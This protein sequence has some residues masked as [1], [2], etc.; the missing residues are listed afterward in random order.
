MEHD[1]PLEPD[2]LVEVVEEGVDG[3]R[4]ADV[5]P[6]RPGV[7]RVEA[8]PEPLG[9]DAPGQRRHRGCPA[10]SVTSV[11]SPNPL[12]GEFSRTTIA[13]SGPS[14][15]SASVSASPSARRRVPAAT[16]APRCDP[17]WTL[18][19]RPRN[20]GAARRSLART[21]TERPKKSSSGP[22]RLTRYE[23]WM[24][25]GR[26]VELGQAR[27]EGRLLASAARPGGARRSGCR[28]RSGARRR[29][30]RAPG[31]RP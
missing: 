29:R 16:P 10:S 19:N 31:R 22:A 14:S 15:T 9:G 23:A 4:L 12:P 5:D 21:S 3:G 20:P 2:P 25:I 26:D 6:G 8:E 30:S 17:T 24:A 27:P 11:P 18:T 28:R 1:Q 13:A 7:G